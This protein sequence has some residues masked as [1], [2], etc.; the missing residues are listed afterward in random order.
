MR[1]A[2]LAL[3]RHGPSGVSVEPLARDLGVTKGSFY[4]H[5]RDRADLLE[6]LLAEWEA[7]A[8]I[9]LEAMGESDLQATLPAMFAEFHRR[10]IASERGEWP[11]DA[12]MFA[13]ASVDPVV[14]K[15]VNR[16]EAQRID[17]LRQLTRRDEMSMLCYYAYE[18]L[19]ARRRRVPSAMEDFPMIASAAMELLAGDVGVR[20]AEKLAPRPAPAAKRG[21]RAGVV[22]GLAAAALLLGGCTTYRIVRWRDPS[23]DEQHRIFAGR[24]VRAAAVPFR[25]HVAPPRTDLDTVRVRDVDG[26]LRPFAEYFARRSIRAFV[27]VRDDSILYE[28]Y[29]TARGYG[30]D[31]RSSSFS[32]AKSVTSALLGIALADGKIRSLDDS[33]ARYLPELARNRAFDGVTLRHLLGMRSGLAYSRTNGSWWHDLRSSDARFYYTTNR[34]GMVAGMRRENPPGTRWAYKDADTEILALVLARATGKSLSAQLEE[35][36]WRRIG[37][38]RA[39]TFDLD[40][41]GGVESASSGLN[42]TARDFARFGR[43]YLHGGQWNGEQVVPAEWVRASTTLDTTRTEP[44]VVT[45]FRMQHQQYWW[46]PMQNWAAERDFYAD[47]SRGQR[48]YVHPPTRTI[49]V[50]L[51]DDSNQEFPFRRVAHYLAGE[52]YRYPVPIAGAVL[53]AGRQFG[54]DSVRAVFGRLT[55]AMRADPAGYTLNRAGLASVAATLRAEKRF[56]AARAV[57]E[58]LARWYGPVARR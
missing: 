17:W 26:Q 38:E 9:L 28:R 39:A 21:R 6:A 15:R 37:T 10:A 16:H 52:P 56:E 49:I 53:R 50:Q 20:L 33:V 55:T 29:D 48:I 32:V 36:I 35:S 51:A 23:P 18:G 40:R 27:V 13:W 2:R 1:A 4:W 7:E 5:F 25:F 44:E 47:G 14:A 19:L 8:A 30:P 43:L 12:A 11:S 3:L 45:W 42:A 31:K 24:E 46:L 54:A 22:M 34:P 57:V 41:A 58:L